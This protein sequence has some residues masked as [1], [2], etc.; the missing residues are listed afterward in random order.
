MLRMTAARLPDLRLV[1]AASAPAMPALL[2]FRAPL[3]VL[4]ERGP[5]ERR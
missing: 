4:A 1:D 3:R 2:S 5:A